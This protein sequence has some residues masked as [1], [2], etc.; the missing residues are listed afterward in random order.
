MSADDPLLGTALNGSV[1]KH[2]YPTGRLLVSSSHITSLKQ[3]TF[4]E[5]AVCASTRIFSR[6][7]FVPGSAVLGSGSKALTILTCT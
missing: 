4:F 2:P 1:Y 3:T 5:K 7:G 6:E